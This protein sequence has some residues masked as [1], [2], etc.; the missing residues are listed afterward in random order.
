MSYIIH[1]VQLAGLAGGSYEP[2]RLSP[3]SFAS[4]PFGEFAEYFVLILIKISKEILKRH[5][6][7]YK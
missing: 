2:L 4:S 3:F 1:G 5:C 6:Y 7:L